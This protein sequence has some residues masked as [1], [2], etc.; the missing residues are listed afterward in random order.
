MN[1]RIRLYLAFMA[2]LIAVLTVVPIMSAQDQPQSTQSQTSPPSNSPAPSDQPQYR[3][4]QN[5]STSTPTT[6]RNVI[7][8][9]GFSWGT[10]LLGL[11]PGV[12]IGFMIG[13]R[14]RKD[15]EIRRGDEIGRGGKAA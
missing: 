6:E 15:F 12:L 11:V 1:S 3:Q 10:F 9:R 7:E 14:P 2:L 4:N 8:D 13:K 5:N